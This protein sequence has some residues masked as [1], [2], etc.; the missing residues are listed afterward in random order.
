MLIE[1]SERAAGPWDLV[2]SPRGSSH[3]I[4]CTG[5]APALILAVGARK[6]KGSVRYPVHLTA[7]R[8]GAGVPDVQTSADQ[9]Y[10]GFGEPRRGPAPDVL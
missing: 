10:D 9:V 3:T 1:G 4:V 6:Q 5:E 2:H 7:I 8:R